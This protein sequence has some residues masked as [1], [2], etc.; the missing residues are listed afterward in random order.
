M[1]LDSARMLEPGEID[2]ASLRW[3]NDPCKIRNGWNKS[4]GS[5][6]SLAMRWFRFAHLISPLVTVKSENEALIED[7]HEYIFVVRGLARTT[8]RGY[9][10]R[11]TSFLNWVSTRRLALPGL[12]L[13]DVEDYLKHCKD[14]CLLPRTICSICNALRE[15][16]RYAATRGLT[17]A[18]IASNI[19]GPHISKYDV[20]PKGPD[21][22]DVRRLLDHGFGSTPSEL[23]AAA[24]FSLCSIYAL[25]SCEVVALTLADLDWVA[26]T[27][28][29]RRA[30]NGK[31]QQFPLQFEVGETILRYLRGGRARCSCRNLFVTTKPPFRPMNP[32]STWK[33]V[34]KRLKALGIESE[35]FGVHGLRHSC[36]TRLLREGSSLKDIAEFL[37]HNDLTSVSIYAKYDSRTLQQVAAFSLAGVK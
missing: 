4:S 37:G 32:C 19:I 7:F 6:R 28:T 25:R 31:T 29:V 36:A 17:Q 13:S 5:F 15:F 16:F 10:A 14:M 35:S 21:W 34:A 3:A 23:R 27:L 9:V 8:I 30:K 18:K 1:E 11:S 24:L 20:K 26:E 22:K 33:M 12:L 2:A